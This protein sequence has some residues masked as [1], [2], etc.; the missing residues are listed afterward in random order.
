MQIF[1]HHIYEYQK[2][3]RRL[4]LHTT[5]ADQRLKIEGRLNKLD[6]AY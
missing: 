2:G 6:I 3:L 4:V 5:S 1:D